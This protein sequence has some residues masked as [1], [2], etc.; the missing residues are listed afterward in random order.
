M[1]CVTVATIDMPGA[2]STNPE[3]AG[4]VMLSVVVQEVEQFT[5]GENDAPATVESPPWNTSGLP[6]RAPAAPLLLVRLTEMGAMPG[7]SVPCWMGK[8]V[9]LN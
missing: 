5:F 8:P 9:P 2:A 6:E 1:G 4:R 7:A 3:P